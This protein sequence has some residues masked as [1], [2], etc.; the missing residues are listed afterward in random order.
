[1]KVVHVTKL[2]NKIYSSFDDTDSSQ[3]NLFEIELKNK[4]RNRLKYVIRCFSQCEE[5]NV[6]NF[7]EEQ[8]KLHGK[9]GCF[10]L[11]VKRK[12]SKFALIEWNQNTSILNSQIP[13]VKQ[14]KLPLSTFSGYT[15]ERPSFYHSFK[16]SIDCNES[17]WGYENLQYWK[18]A[19][20]NG[21]LKII[22]GLTIS[23]SDYTTALE[24]LKERYSN[25]SES[26]LEN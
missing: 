18:F 8:Q 1:M 24:L 22:Q 12:N 11:S 4:A 5:Q 19:C 15:E 13:E 10:C 23:N 21:A 16:A 3:H 9:L 26:W 17:L 2:E 6:G 7:V 20:K 14:P 25:E